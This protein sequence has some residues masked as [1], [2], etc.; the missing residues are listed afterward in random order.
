MRPAVE[1]TNSARFSA[2]DDAMSIPT[3][4]H[5]ERCAKA[6]VG[7]RS[8]RSIVHSKHFKSSLSEVESGN[9]GTIATHKILLAC[10]L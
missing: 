8:S 9:D 3:S 2:P 4:S 7:M 1:R 5:F 6:F 10:G